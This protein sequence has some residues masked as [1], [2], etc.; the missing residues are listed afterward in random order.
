M[1]V[2]TVYRAGLTE[3]VRPLGGTASELMVMLRPVVALPAALVAATKYA[4]AEVTAVG[5]PEMTPVELSR[6]RPAGS[7]GDTEYLTTTPPLLLGV[8]LG[9][10]VPTA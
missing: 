10:A 5:V 3:Y 2:P 9:M 4:V 8:L 1:A 6:L 7:A